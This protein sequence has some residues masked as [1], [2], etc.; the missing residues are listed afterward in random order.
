MRPH[1]AALAGALVVVMASG[2]RTA[3]P[4]APSD[5]KPVRT[6]AT[7]PAGRTVEQVVAALAPTAERRL[8]ERFATAGVAYP[9]KSAYLLA[10]K[11]ERE[12]ELWA[13][14]GAGR[15][16]VAVYPLLDDSGSIGPKLREGDYQIPE[17][18]YR[19]LWLHP[20]SQYHLSMKLDY[21]NA[22]DRARA[23]DDGRTNLGGDIFIHGGDASIGC[24]AIGDPAI[25]ELFV[26]AARIGAANVKTIVAPWDLRS[27]PAP[28]LPGLGLA[29]L[30]QLYSQLMTSLAAF[31]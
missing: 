18:F 9:P 29:W 19:I 8:R 26:L 13:D 12:V 30:P 24:L 3:A 6:G 27:R 4:P 7:K 1:R 25:E 17:G 22:F 20:N 31:R 10:F 11:T 15:R 28:E 2:C 5:S 16:K 14:S 23:E 21:P